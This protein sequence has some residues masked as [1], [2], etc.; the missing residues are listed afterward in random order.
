MAEDELLKCGGMP[1]THCQRLLITTG[2]ALACCIG[3]WFLH[4]DGR[5]ISPMWPAAGV[6]MAFF[7]HYGWRAAPWVIVGHLS[8]WGLMQPGKLTWPILLLPLSYP[9][10]AWLVSLAGYRNR[11]MMGA[12]RNAMWPVAWAYLVAPVV[13]VLPVLFLTTLTFTSTGIFPADGVGTTFLLLLLAHVQGI[14][15][16]GSLSLHV[17]H[18]DFNCAELKKSW[19]GVLAGMA[20]LVIM[21]L[22][23]VGTFDY[24]LNPGSAIFLPFPLLV[25]AAVC[26]SPAP[27]SL[28]VAFWCV[29]STALVSFGLSPFHPIIH[30]GRVVPSV[31]I[32]M[33][34][35]VTSSV[36]YLIS[37]GRYHFS[38]Q[39]NL[40]QITLA[41]AGIELWEWE[42]GR[43]FSWIQNH[44]SN[45]HVRE[46]ITGWHH[47]DMLCRLA[48]SPLD[49]RSISDSWRLRIQGGNP[50]KDDHMPR[51]M[52]ESAGRVLQ[53]GIDHRP[54]K[55]I[56]L[57][58]DISARYQAEEALVALGY[59]KAKL[60]SLEA[61]LTPHFFF[62][63]LNVIQS[64]IHI[65]PKTADAA[66]TSLA[67]LLRSNLR[68]TE[69]SLIA[70]EEE[71]ARIR[72]LLHL[73]RLRFGTRLVTRIRVPGYLLG[74]RIPPMLLLN[75]V[76]NAITHGI[77][78]LENGGM[79]SLTAKRTPESVEISIRNSGT[80][81]ENAIRGLGTRDALQRLEILFAGKA[82]FSLSQMDEK[83]VSAEIHLPITHPSHS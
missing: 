80:L 35:I 64:L 71:L 12:N 40:N 78:N 29:L 72:E 59:Q 1:L 41:T 5:L 81:P 57:L 55:A 42:V 62:N 24:F 46:T 76:E 25:M 47:E 45:D 36:A 19:H 44:S 67:S 53:R 16:F 69:N 54:T 20:A 2:T 38:R 14:M 66:V 49:Q 3:F 13:G 63:S 74:T 79:I 22:A 7:V 17:L 68:T 34:N 82:G 37:V 9:L 52:L 39:L 6:S 77:G 83:T 10:E 21:S 11:R 18:R 56:G 33:Y 58:Q 4:L 60:R 15:A 73:A 23:I 70:L 75:L 27:A 48:G 28:L 30:G 43:G 61:K 65:D 50:F 51:L 31:E 32:V 26:L 8:I